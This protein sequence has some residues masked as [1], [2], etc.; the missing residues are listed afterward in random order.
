MEEQ[1][2]EDIRNGDYTS[3]KR[4]IG[5]IDL[6]DVFEFS[7]ISGL[8]EAVKILLE[9]E[10]VVNS[11]R[12]MREVP[13]SREV[14]L[15]V[16]DIVEKVSYAT[17]EEIAAK[18]PDLLSLFFPKCDKIHA[19]KICRLILESRFQ[20]VNIEKF[21]L[22]FGNESYFREVSVRKPLFEMAVEEARKYFY[23]GSWCETIIGSF[24][25]TVE[26][27]PGRDLKEIV[28]EIFEKPQEILFKNLI[29]S[30]VEQ[31]DVEPED[32]LDITENL[33]QK[34]TEFLMKIY[35][36]RISS[37][38]RVE[39]SE[40]VPFIVEKI[41]KKKIDY[42]IEKRIEKRLPI[43]DLLKMRETM[44]LSDALYILAIQDVNTKFTR[45]K[46]DRETFYCLKDKVS[47]PE[48]AEEMAIFGSMK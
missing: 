28:G 43:S 16:A 25:S 45:L 32:I 31:F 1:I 4:S 6:T 2:I 19:K 3:L 44:T 23:D 48:F 8:T 7:Y 35:Q 13:D 33:Y 21:I 20:S 38:R 27:F 9:D 5:K 10:S 36:S 47:L 46:I 12:K 37:K 29:F 11:V 17:L 42:L 40:K 22:H 15:S 34:R 14:L 26:T 39:Y 24:Y 18:H 30:L 41:P